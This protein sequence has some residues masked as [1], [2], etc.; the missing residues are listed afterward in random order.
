MPRSRGRR[1]SPRSSRLAARVTRKGASLRDLD[2]QTRLFKYPCSYL[3]YSDGFTQLP[4]RSRG[5]VVLQ[6]IR[7]VL[8]G[9]TSRR[10]SLTSPPQTDRRFS[11]S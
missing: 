4:R 8:T 1:C 3:I 10:S 2:L 9:E 6:R 7:A 11:R 5:D